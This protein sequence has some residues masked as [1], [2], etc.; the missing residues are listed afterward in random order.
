M[1]HK[2]TTTMDKRDSLTGDVRDVLVHTSKCHPLQATYSLGI[3][4]SALSSPPR[5]NPER[6]ESLSTN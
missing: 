2:R 5:R 3:T 1:S 6:G 4:P